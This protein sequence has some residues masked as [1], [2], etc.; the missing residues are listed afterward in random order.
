[1]ED[2]SRMARQPLAHGR[3]LVGGIVVE[4]RVDGLAGGNGALGESWI[5][6][7]MREGRVLS[8][9]RPSKPSA[10]KRSCQRQTQVL[11]L[12]VSCTIA[13]MAA[14]S[15]LSN[16]IQA[17]QTCFCGALRSRT[18][19]RSRSRSAGRTEREMPLRI[20]QIRTPRTSQESPKG[21]KCQ[22]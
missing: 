14:P 1:M 11:D 10:A 8:R 3:M 15:A 20:P 22:I 12:P 7:L 13:F 9:R 4:D 21:F 16:T 19:A 2:P 6:L 17:R 5:E 18:N